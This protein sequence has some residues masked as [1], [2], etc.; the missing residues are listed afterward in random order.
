MDYGPLLRFHYESDADLT[1]AFTARDTDAGRF[2]IAEL[3]AAGQIMN[4]TEKPEVPRTHL[5]SMSVYLFRRE[6]M[7]EELRRAVSGEDEESTV[8]FQIHEVLRRM[9]SRRRAYGFIHHGA[10]AYAR[11]LDE[12]YAFHRD[13]LGATPAVDLAEWKVY[14]NVTA[15]RTAPP[16]PARFLPGA[17]ITNSLV[18]PGCVIEGTVENSVLSPGVRVGP[19]AVVKDCVLWHDVVVEEDA[20]ATAII[21]DK[22]VVFGRGCRVGVGEPA[23]SEEKPRALACGAT[24]L[25]MNV[26]VP[27]GARIGRNC[28]IHTEVRP[29][30][31][32]AVVPSGQSVWPRARLE[33]R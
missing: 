7:V 25:A 8:T 15:G 2:G 19:R 1:M 28:L 10:W 12:Y 33:R 4:F 32:G 6:V 11:T 22:R 23:P 5:A 3:N 24:V 26:R 9:I 16:P 27:P 29:D 14:S 31:I 21:A 18:S 17:T 20:E 30:D 13:L